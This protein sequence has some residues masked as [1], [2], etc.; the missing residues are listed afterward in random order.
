MAQWRPVS[1]PRRGLGALPV[2]FAFVW[3]AFFATIFW[4]LHF[5]L[6]NT[7]FR[8]FY[9]AGLSWRGIPV[10]AADYRV[11]LNTPVVTPVFAL[12]SHLSLAQAFLVWTLGSIAAFGLSLHAIHRRQAF[13]ARDVVWMVPLLTVSMPALLVWTEGQVTWWLL[14]LATRAWLAPTPGRAGLWLAPLL[15]IKP[16]L[17]PLALLLPV[18]VAAT[19]GGA[20]AVLGGL[21]VLF[22]GWAPWATWL[23]QDEAILWLTWYPN[24]SIAGVVGRIEEARLTMAGLRDLSWGWIAA[25]AAASAVLVPLT[26]RRT[27]PARWSLALFSA[28][29]IFPL[30]WIYYLPIGLGWLRASWPANRVAIAGLVLLSVPFHWLRVFSTNPVGIVSSG[31]IYAV[32]VVLLVVGWSRQRATSTGEAVTVQIPTGP[33]PR[34]G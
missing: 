4:T 10:A 11:N 17:L 5:N 28:T 30:G 6:I 18:P 31:S 25:T 16:S 26:M 2:V 8:S 19:A 22:Q 15:V 29:L 1:P 33:G 20:A 12:L 34:T 9:E 3:P 32:A 13:G 21:S 7:D 14:L 27:G 24:A 23:S